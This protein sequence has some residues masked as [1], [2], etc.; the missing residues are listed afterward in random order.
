MSIVEYWDEKWRQ[1]IRGDS[2][3]LNLA[4]AHYLLRYLWK[5]IDWFPLEKLEV[6]CGSCYHAKIISNTCKEW[7]DKYTGIDLSPEAVKSAQRFGVNAIVADITTFES[8]RKYELFIFMDVLEHI[9]DHK[10]TAE[11]VRRLAAD[12]YYIFGNVPL[13]RSKHETE[14]GFERPM[15]ISVLSA[16]IKSCGIEAFTHHIYGI[17]GWPY[18]RF[19]ACN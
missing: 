11:A 14:G 16:F 2:V 4:K 13:Y 8:D 1:R 9:E 3:I 7:L 18:M 12:R 6:G 5:K 10:A 17:D 19:E 15:N